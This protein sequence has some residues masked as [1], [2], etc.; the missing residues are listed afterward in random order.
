MQT[1]PDYARRPLGVYVDPDKLILAR[2]ARITP[3]ELHK[4]AGR[5]GLATANPFDPIKQL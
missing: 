4:R 3:R 5:G 2:E 1:S